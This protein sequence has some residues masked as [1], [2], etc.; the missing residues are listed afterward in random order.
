MKKL[1]LIE[2]M[3]NLEES[4]L[5]KEIYRQLI[6]PDSWEKGHW[7]EPR[8][9]ANCL[10]VEMPDSKPKG[11]L[12]QFVDEDTI[13]PTPASAPCADSLGIFK[14]G[15]GRIDWLKQPFTLYSYQNLLF[16]LCYVL[17][18]GGMLLRINNL[19]FFIKHKH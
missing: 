14:P 13:Y 15:N 16:K 1:K 12:L 4:L 18:T 8:T 9:R 5:G 11:I 7:R 2:T 3:V 19:L 10:A 6:N 17:K